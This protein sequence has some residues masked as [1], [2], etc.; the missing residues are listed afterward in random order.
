M[1]LYRGKPVTVTANGFG[2]YSARVDL[3]DT[4][5]GNTGG[6]AL[7]G[8]WA[9]IRAAA[10]RAL[11]AELGDQIGAGYQL[12]LEVTANRFDHTNI[13]RSFTFTEKDET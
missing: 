1:T 7:D 10:R 11:R 2:L 12:R 9:G 8:H 6:L 4:G 5:Y 3:P 13:A